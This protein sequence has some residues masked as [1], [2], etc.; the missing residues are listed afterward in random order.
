MQVNMGKD[1][2]APIVTVFNAAR[3]KGKPPQTVTI[4]R[5]I[6]AIAVS[7]KNVS[8]ATT[9]FLLVEMLLV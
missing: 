8:M 4:E 6:A 1:T 9:T 5:T 2:L 3:R 7:A